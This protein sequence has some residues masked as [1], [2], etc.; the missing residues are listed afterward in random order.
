MALAQ[1]EIDE[2]IHLIEK[3]IAERPE[4]LNANVRY[5]LELRERAIRVEEELR[6]N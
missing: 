5:E 1:E 2:I 6:R 3:V 4:I